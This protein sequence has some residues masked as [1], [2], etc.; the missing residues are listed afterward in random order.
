L[1]YGE[2]IDIMLAVGG[3]YIGARSNP[4]CRA[5]EKKWF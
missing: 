4:S 2:T 1:I 3:M 5:T